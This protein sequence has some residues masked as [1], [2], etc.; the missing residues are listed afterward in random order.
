VPSGALPSPSPALHEPVPP[1]LQKVTR[2]GSALSCPLW[3]PRPL[4]RSPPVCHARPAP[5]LVSQPR[6]G[7]VEGRDAAFGRWDGPAVG[8]RHQTRRGGGV[9]G[10]P[11]CRHSRRIRKRTAR[12][13]AP[14]IVAGDAQPP[15][16]GELPVTPPTIIPTAR[17]IPLVVTASVAAHDG[18][19]SHIFRNDRTRTI[20]KRRAPRGDS[21]TRP[22]THRRGG[23]RNR[24]GVPPVHAPA[25]NRCAQE[26]EKKAATSVGR[27][28]SARGD[29]TFVGG[30]AA[31]GGSSGGEPGGGHRNQNDHD[32][33]C[34]GG[35]SRP[36]RPHRAPVS[37]ACDRATGDTD[38][39]REGLGSSVSLGW[40]TSTSRRG[41][42]PVREKCGF[43]AS[44]QRRGRRRSLTEQF[45]QPRF[46]QQRGEKTHRRH[47]S[48]TNTESLP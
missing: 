25:A 14:K 30:A 38:N 40:R 22:H 43:T 29:G 8:A 46:L 15:P 32:G 34:G 5:P 17:S 35:G 24:V 37:V 39:R 45:P 44:V 28:L 12:R 27:T 26:T 2:T 20:G 18:T 21:E 19:E 1:L 3:P 47:W 11:R 33:G 48:P 16:E 7:H 4:L 36:K 23:A 41:R 13:W 6:P 42:V 31:D 9:S 10:G